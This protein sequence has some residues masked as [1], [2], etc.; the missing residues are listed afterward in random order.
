MGL[1]RWLRRRSSTTTAPSRRSDRATREITRLPSESAVEI[2]RLEDRAVLSVDVVDLAL[3]NVAE[4]SAAGTVVGQVQATQ[5]GTANPL[6]YA[7]T[8]G[9]DDGA[10]AINGA[11][12][13]ITVA[14]GSKLDFETHPLHALTVSATSTLD[15]TQTDSGTANVQ[16]TDV[17]AP[18]MVT[19]AGGN[20]TLSV[21]GGNLHVAQGATV[22][23][24]APLEDV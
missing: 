7:I 11:T 4:N 1:S 24:N 8:G 5:S 3:F 17:F 6:A 12:G 14:D 10:F 13:Q 16:L 19:L 9:N 2:R 21:V 20:A 15:P 22:L 23:L 18:A